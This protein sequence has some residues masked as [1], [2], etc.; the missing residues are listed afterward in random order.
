MDHR[1]DAQ[2][3]RRIK[4]RTRALFIHDSSFVEVSSARTQ[5]VRS[6]RLLTYLDRLTRLPYSKVEVKTAIVNLIG[7]L[8]KGENNLWYGTITFQQR[9]RGMNSDGQVL[10][11]DVTTKKMEVVLKQLLETINGEVI[12][13]WEVF[14]SNI[15]VESTRPQ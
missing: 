10:Y 2:E 12:S 9:F 14:L 1:I 15:K 4:N 11:E 5:R 7:D 6:F 13:Q 8:R 3:V